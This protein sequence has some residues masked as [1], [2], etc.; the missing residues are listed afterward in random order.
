MED[1]VVDGFVVLSEYILM[2]THVSKIN[3]KK[4]IQ[5]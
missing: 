4:K 1:M 3:H 2:Y 5:N